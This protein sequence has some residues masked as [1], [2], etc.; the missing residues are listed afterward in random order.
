M[1]TSTVLV[2]L[3][4][5]SASWSASCAD[6]LA[7]LDPA[8]VAAPADAERA[9]AGARKE[10]LSG[11]SP[12]PR[13]GWKHTASRLVAALGHPVH[14]ASDVIVA[15]GKTAPLAAKFA[16]GGAL[17]KDLEDEWI[18]VFVNDCTAW[19]YV[20]WGTTNDDGRVTFNLAQNL[21]PGVYDVRMEV[22]GDATSAALRLWVLPAGT[23]L[24]VF[25]ID[26]TLTT[27]DGEI[28]EEILLGWTPESY[29][30]ALDVTWAEQGRD[31]VVVYLT[32]RPEILAA[33]TRAWLA[34]RG[35]PAGPLKLT[36]SA[37][38]VVPTNGG[39]GSYK[40]NFLNGLRAAGLLLDEAFGNASTDIYAY[41]RAGI[42]KA[43]TWI[44]GEN[45]GDGGTIAVAGG[46]G[47][48]ADGLELEPAVDQPGW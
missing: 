17:S 12:A 43:R 4:I 46:W 36:R 47:A 23:H 45:G 6:G 34:G 21:A 10:C 35:F 26:G 13:A 39:V 2:T 3:A 44:I 27:D 29:P 40:T 28:F 37:G 30:A 20:G 48:V 7:P 5:L 31:Q 16:Y 25:D 42:P 9:L 38:E 19:R 15:P 32:G 8:D 14:S 22:V 24:A 18:W 11:F 41:E 33:Q 1:R